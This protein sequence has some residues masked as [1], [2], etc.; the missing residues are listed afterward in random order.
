MV[1]LA[2]IVFIFALIQLLIALINL[3]FQQPAPLCP[4]DNLVS[5]LVPA[6]NEEKNIGPLLSS[7]TNQDYQNIE[8]LIFDDKS[9]DNTAMMIKKAAKLDNRIRYI[10]ADSLPEGWLGKNF[11]CHTLSEKACGKYFLFL[12]ADVIIGD[13]VIKNSIASIEKEELGLLSFFPVQVMCTMA[14]KITV[15]NM[16]YILLSLLPLVFVQKSKN[17]AVAA[18]NGQFMFYH[19]E[20][21]RMYNPHS[22]LRNKNVEDIEAARYL[23]MNG[24]RISCRAAGENIKCRMYTSYEDAID[25]FSRNIIMYFGNSFLLATLFWLVTS[26]GFLIVYFIFHD[27]W[28]YIYLLTVALTRIFTSIT[29]KQPVLQNLLLIIPQQI[30]MGIIIYK[31]FL[32]KVK[33]NMV[34]KDRNISFAS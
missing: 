28:F 7:L 29:S 14:E 30:T 26:F 22:I 18:A 21:Y 6:R 19:S 25:G 24:V 15:P 20:V 27:F 10:S 4:N 31:A 1:Y 23:K 32:N 34:W 12:D 5:I 2:S 16:N 33:K 13:H 3:I 9:T 8:I 11:A 17:P